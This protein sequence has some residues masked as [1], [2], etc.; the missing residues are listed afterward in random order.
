[1]FRPRRKRRTRRAGPSLQQRRG[2][3]YWADDF[4]ARRLA[5]EILRS[6]HHEKEH[7][8]LCPFWFNRENFN[9]FGQVEG[10]PGEKLEFNLEGF[11]Y[12]I[13]FG[14]SGFFLQFEGFFDPPHQG[15]ES[16]HPNPEVRL[17]HVVSAI[18]DQ[19]NGDNNW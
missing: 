3:E 8:V 2:L 10:M 17:S 1:M 15:R 13:A 19:L 16:V 12:R 18:T 4:A 11:L 14:I 6:A 9:T 7:Y 5:L